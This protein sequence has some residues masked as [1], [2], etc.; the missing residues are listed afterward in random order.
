MTTK[1]KNRAYS[2]MICFLGLAAI[3]LALIIVLQ[4][5]KE[6][7]PEKQ[8]SQTMEVSKE[9]VSKKPAEEKTSEASK[10][11][12][13]KEVKKEESKKEESKKEES[14]KKQEESKEES[15]E[16][17]SEESEESEESS[18][19]IPVNASGSGTFASDTGTSLNL[20]VEWNLDGETLTLNTYIES[21]GISVSDRYEGLYVTIDGETE[22]YTTDALDVTAEDL[23]SVPLRSVSVEWPGGTHEVEVSWRF[24]G[25]YNDQELEYITASERISD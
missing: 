23:V 12:S 20:I 25:T 4:P 13:Q 18:T 9:E 11:E 22:I 21:Y 10:Q 7:E 14:S 1:Q 3:V 6:K 24:F 2:L 8:S 15:S 19:D 16:E 17:S 5:K